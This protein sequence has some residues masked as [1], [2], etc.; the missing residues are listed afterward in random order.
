MVVVEELSVKDCGALGAVAVDRAVGPAAE[1]GADEPL[2]L[3]IGLGAVRTGAQ[4]AD[5]EHAAGD[6]VH[7]QGSVEASGRRRSAGSDGE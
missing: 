1:H 2:C 6:R 3:A 7:G 5:T 4:V